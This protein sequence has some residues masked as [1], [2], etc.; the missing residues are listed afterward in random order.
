ML[1]KGLF[2]LRNG[3]S[4]EL[5]LPHVSVHHANNTVHLAGED[6][7]IKIWSRSGMLRSTL[8]QHSNLALYCVTNFSSIRLSDLLVFMG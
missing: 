7:Q 3:I 2:Y 4:M 1:I 8:C 5:L 6:G